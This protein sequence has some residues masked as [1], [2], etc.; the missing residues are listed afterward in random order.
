[1][2]KQ[3]KPLTQAQVMEE[4]I[5]RTGLS[6]SEVRK[7]FRAQAEL[8]VQQLKRKGINAIPIP[9]LGVKLVLKRKPATKARMGRNPATGEE[10]MIKAKPACNVVKATILK[11]LKDQVL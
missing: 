7:F 9:E 6:K 1:M 2:A 4:M 3:T 11:K 10:M 8:A 5:E